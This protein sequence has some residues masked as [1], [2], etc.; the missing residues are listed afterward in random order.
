MA[1]DGALLFRDEHH[2]TIAGS[3]KAV[4]ELRKQISFN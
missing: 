4:D 2:L 1:A 3:L